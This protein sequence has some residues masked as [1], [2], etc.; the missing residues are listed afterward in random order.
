MLVKD[1]VDQLLL[2]PQDLDI[3][4]QFRDSDYGNVLESVSDIAS[5]EVY[6]TGDE[7][8]VEAPKEPVSFWTRDA[9]TVEIPTTK[10]LMAVVKA[11]SAD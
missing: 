7:L 1:M 4:V 11:Q 2:L 9:G 10:V 5:Q 6:R 8:S 3:M